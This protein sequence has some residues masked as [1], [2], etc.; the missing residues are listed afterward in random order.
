VRDFFDEMARTHAPEIW[1][2]D[3]DFSVWPLGHTAVVQS[4]SQWAKAPRKLVLLANDYEPLAQRHPRWVAW[5]RHWTHVVSCK[6]PL[7]SESLD[8]PTM[9]VAPGRLTIQRFRGVRCRGKI[10]RDELDIEACRQEFD[11]LL[12]RSGDSF[13]AS[14][15]G[16]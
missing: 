12:Q 9:L 13:S 6:A 8:V 11:A 16:L 14:V 15:L 1:V 5:R 4:L 3:T 10:S 2:S 7:P